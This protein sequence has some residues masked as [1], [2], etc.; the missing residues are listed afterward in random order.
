[1]INT[2]MLTA[3]IQSMPRLFDAHDVINEVGHRNQRDY[4]E[5]LSSNKDRFPFNTVHSE[6]GRQIKDIC[7]S[8]GYEQVDQPDYRSKDIF[9]QSSLCNLWRKRI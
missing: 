5:Q 6:L 4:I 9:R 3:A 7:L 8:L 2:G 1:M